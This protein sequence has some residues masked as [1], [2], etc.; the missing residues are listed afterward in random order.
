MGPNEAK[1][2]KTKHK[3]QHS[4]SMINFMQSN[5]G[6]NDL[7]PLNSNQL[8]PVSQSREFILSYRDQQTFGPLIRKDSLSGSQ[9][10]QMIISLP[11]KSIS[12]EKAA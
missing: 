7:P 4:M 3:Q 8:D 5:S 2:S 1:A 9:E 11:N 12:G 6:A 10:N